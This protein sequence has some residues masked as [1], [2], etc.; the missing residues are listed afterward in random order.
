MVHIGIKGA[1]L[2]EVQIW[3]QFAVIRTEVSKYLMCLCVNSIAADPTAD[4]VDERAKPQQLT[5]HYFQKDIMHF[6]SHSVPHV[7]HSCVPSRAL[8]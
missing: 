2:R 7:S 8:L 3:K 4:C 6:T 1:L 5:P